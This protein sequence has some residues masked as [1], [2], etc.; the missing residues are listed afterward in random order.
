[1]LALSL[2]LSGILI[3]SG[4]NRIHSFI[5]KILKMKNLFSILTGCALLSQPNY[6]GAQVAARGQ[7]IDQLFS[8]VARSGVTGGDTA[9]STAKPGG[10]NK[11]LR[12]CCEK[13]AKAAAADRG[14]GKERWA[15][16]GGAGFEF[17]PGECAA[18]LSR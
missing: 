2:V 17:Y 12:A 16:V 15:A 5:Y 6:A 11:E 9:V 8:T 10:V 14:I 18:D 7:A 3:L 4:R 13:V 1:L